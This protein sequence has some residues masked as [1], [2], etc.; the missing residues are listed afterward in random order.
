LENYENKIVKFI[1]LG[2]GP[3]GIEFICELASKYKTS[4]NQNF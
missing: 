2:A 3:V 1:V 4:Q